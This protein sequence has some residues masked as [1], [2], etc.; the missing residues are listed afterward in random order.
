MKKL[1]NK[2]NK[3]DLTIGL[4]YLIRFVLKHI[5]QNHFQL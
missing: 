4:F 3:K 2:T 5:Q 1:S